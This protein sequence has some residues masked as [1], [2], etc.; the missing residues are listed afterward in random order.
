MKAS[1]IRKD[2]QAALQN[3]VADM[4]KELEALYLQKATGGLENPQKIKEVKRDVARV[5][6]IL[7]EKFL[8]ESDKNE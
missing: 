8:Q 2:E 7:R 6:T 3:R 5:L 1:E 4:R